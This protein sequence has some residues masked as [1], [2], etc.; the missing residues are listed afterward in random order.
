MSFEANKSTNIELL[1]DAINSFNK[2]SDTLVQYYRSLEEKVTALTQEVDH[3]KQLLNSILDSID[4]GVV[5]FD[6]N[7]IIRM[8]NR[9]VEELLSVTEAEIIGRSSLGVVIDGDLMIPKNSKPFHALISRRDVYDKAG[10]IIGNVLIFKDI[11]RIKELETINE[12][13]RRLT[14]MGE[15]VMKIAHEIRNP[16]GSIEL[17]AS[18][19]QAD[20]KENSQADYVK[21]ISNSVRSLVN[22][23]DNM[24]SFA[25]EIKPNINLQY[26][27]PVINEAIDELAGTL[28]NNRVACKIHCKGDY[29]VPIDKG[30]I[31]QALLNILINAIQAMKDGGIISI[32]IGNTK[33][34]HKTFLY[35]K[36]SDKG[37]GIE[38]Q[39]LASIFEPFYSTKDRGTGL[40]LSI[41]ASIIKAHKGYITVDSKINKGT[42]FTLHIPFDIENGGI[43]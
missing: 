6:S 34:D 39:R 7:G 1:S 29:S 22:T 18:L 19:L 31:K 9:S 35:I 28:E 17:F 24:L 5:F 15:L 12:R 30:L 13:N 16:L 4:I 26:I 25:R 33:I 43:L 32:R 27:R 20:L 11:S 36:I 42:V 23:L 38:K 37:I 40:G 21:R 41:T 2:V 8:I 3:K 14:A 10:M